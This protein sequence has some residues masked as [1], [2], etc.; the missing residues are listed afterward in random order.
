MLGLQSPK[1]WSVQGN[2]L[3]NLDARSRTALVSAHQRAVEDKVSSIRIV[4]WK[5]RDA[6]VVGTQVIIVP[7]P[8]MSSTFSMWFIDVNETTGTF[9]V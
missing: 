7:I 6:E 9:Q 5:K 2:V 3:E 1:E 4:S 8:F